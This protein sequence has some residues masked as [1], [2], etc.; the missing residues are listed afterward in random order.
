MKPSRRLSLSLLSLLVVSALG[1]VGCAGQIAADNCAKQREHV[2]KLL[3]YAAV[4]SDTNT[5]RKVTQALGHN[6]Y[7][8][9]HILND[10]PPPAEKPP[11]GG[12]LIPVPD[13]RELEAN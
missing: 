9:D 6:F 3:N 11:I 1:A 8:L 13:M 5:L 10:A 2:E 7:T 4:T 12:W